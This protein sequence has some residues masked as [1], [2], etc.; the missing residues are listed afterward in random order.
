M[1]LV[2]LSTNLPYLGICNSQNVPMN[3]HG[4]FAKELLCL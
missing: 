3:S 1:N 4:D 2:N